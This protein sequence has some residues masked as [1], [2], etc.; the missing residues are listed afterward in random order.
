[1][2]PPKPDLS[3]VLLGWPSLLEAAWSAV[4]ARVSAILAGT[5]RHA[6][7]GPHPNITVDVDPRLLEAVDAWV[8]QHPETDRSKVIDEALRL[9]FAHEQRRAMEEQFASPSEVD[10]EEWEAW[11]SIRRAAAARRIGMPD[12]A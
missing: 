4:R 11:R 3:I 12:D 2:A 8:K 7:V 6:G 10:G 9:W 1:M 5:M